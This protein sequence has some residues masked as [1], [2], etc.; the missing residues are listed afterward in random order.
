[1]AE[2]YLENVKFLVVDDNAFM[3]KIVRRVLNALDA[4]QVR[5]AGDGAEA[6]KVMRTFEPDIIICDWEMRP[7][8]GLEFVR[9]LRLS[10]DSANPYI[11]V[12]M[13]SGHS[14]MNRVTA[15]RDAGVNEFV[16]KPISVR[17]LFSRI[18]SIIE[19]PRGFIRTKTFFGPD[20]RRRNMRFKGADRRKA[21]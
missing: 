10:S 11:P 9:M 8:D 17:T 19:K 5:D 6:L 7:L 2:K 18:Q 21:E 16:V 12:I 13:L 15:A 20:R 1:M 4:M 14:E 3:R